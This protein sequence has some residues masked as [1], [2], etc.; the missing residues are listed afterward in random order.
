[1]TIDLKKLPTQ[2]GIYRFY[3]S[4]NKLL[5]IGKAKNL[6][7]RVKSYFQKNNEL[8]PAKK[9]MVSQ[10]KKI[11]YTVVSNET[12]AILLETS[13]IKKYQ[14]PFNIDLKDDKY[15]LYIKINISEPF[16]RIMT[17]RKIDNSKALYFGPYTNAS[18]VYSMMKLLRDV[19]LYRT[20]NRDL[21]KLPKGRVCLL[22]HLNQCLGPCE[23]KCTKTEY[24]RMIK[25]IINFLKGKTSEIVKSLHQE[26]QKQSAN[27]NYEAAAVTRDKIKAIA[28]LQ[29]R[30]KVVLTKNESQDIISIYKTDKVACLNLFK[31]REGKLIDQ[32]NFIIKN[33]G[34]F[35]EAEILA[36]W[37]E[38]YY[39]T[40][41]DKPK[42][43]IIGEKLSTEQL[44]EL[45][46]KQIIIAKKGK[47]ADLIKLG[48]ENAKLTLEKIIPKWQKKDNQALNK[49]TELQ[50]V[51]NLTKLPKRIEGY[52]ISNIQGEL[53]VGSMVVFTNGLADK[54]GYRMF[55]I[56]TVKGANDP[57]MIGEIIKR[58]LNNDWPK[59][60]LILID[61]G[62]SQI[63]AAFYSAGDIDI[64]IISL[65]KREELI[66]K[67]N[68]K[69]PIKLQRTS[70]ALQLLQ[71]LRDEAHR[72]AINY[73]R[74]LRN[75]T[76]FIH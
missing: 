63:N 36:V 14:P 31:I 7:N 6:K 43:I 37:L 58:R 4:E 28:N 55:K 73:H 3:N 34:L 62:P 24:D 66:F 76:F 15:F 59:P 16:P 27:K 12:E 40:T 20:C 57:A 49:I 47:K 69:F 71:Q 48:L 19:F 74:K 23:L 53:A 1:M 10:I 29:I 70:L 21:R 64:P 45:P 61:G 46:I 51:L 5:Y 75:R 39:A 32:Q 35:D 52:D 56:K 25:Q 30:Q 72:F 41:Q 2:P 8:S 60:D 18:S 54:K 38:K 13:L 9:I 22:Y 11:N 67:Y 44:S 26:M 17:V 42:E 68:E 33:I 65:A 50:K